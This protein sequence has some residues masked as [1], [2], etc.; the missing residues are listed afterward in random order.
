MVLVAAAGQRLSLYISATASELGF[1]RGFWLDAAR[2]LRW[3]ERFAEARRPDAAVAPPAALGAGSTCGTCRSATRAA[4]RGRCGRRHC[5]YRPST[6]VAVV[7]ENG[8]GS[9]RW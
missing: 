5:T 9:R 3:L 6:V 4:R 2:R 1:L 7:G 8:A